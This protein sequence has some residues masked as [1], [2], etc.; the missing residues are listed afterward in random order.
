MS[1][2]PV[3]HNDSSWF[4]DCGATI[5]LTNMHPSQYQTCVPYSGSGKV[6]VGNGSSLN[7]AAIG[8]AC[9][10]SAPRPLQ[11][12]NMLFTPGVTKN[13]LYVS[14]FA[15]DNDVFFEFHVSHCVI[16]DSKTHKALLHG[17]ECSGLYKLD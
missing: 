5:H 15:K 9:L 12:H 14:Q 4:P 11:L 1:V 13:L 16:R 8:S 17:H 10:P 6:A 7:I 2:A 3:I